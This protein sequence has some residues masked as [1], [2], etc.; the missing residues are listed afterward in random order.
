G[1]SDGRIDV[2]YKV[3][4]GTASPADFL[5]RADV[6]TFLPGETVKTFKVR[7]TDDALPEADE[8]VLL[9]LSLPT[10]GGLLGNPSAATLTI[11]DDDSSRLAGQKVNDLN[12]NGVR[13]PGEPG[14]NGWT[15]Q[16]VDSTTGAVVATQVTH[17]ID[18]N[19][20]RIIA[21]ETE[22]GLY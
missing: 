5:S 1:G 13:D 16:L 11:R 10:G 7:I 22:Q 19:G 15:I 6:L 17:T 8:T 12:N 9:T 20:D 18:R 21:P 4:S 2:P 14:L 3:F